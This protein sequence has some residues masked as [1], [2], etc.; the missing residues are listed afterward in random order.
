MAKELNHFNF[1]TIGEG[2]EICKLKDVSN[3]EILGKK[4]NVETINYIKNCTAVIFPSIWYEIFGLIIIEAFA[5]GKPV[6][7][8][9][10]GVIQ[11]LIQDGRTGLLFE[12]GNSDDLKEKLSGHLNIKLK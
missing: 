10:L 5:S 7:A 3:I 4:T 9:R 6:I 2:P 8:S 1:K 12:P 11:E